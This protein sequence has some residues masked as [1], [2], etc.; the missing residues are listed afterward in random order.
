MRA[1]VTPDNTR[2]VVGVGLDYERC[3]LSL[4][5]VSYA[6]ALARRN[7]NDVEL[8]SISNVEVAEIEEGVSLILTIKQPVSQNGSGV[9]MPIG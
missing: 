8:A 3:R 1:V 7:D 9:L 4:E 6:M 5:V 2:L